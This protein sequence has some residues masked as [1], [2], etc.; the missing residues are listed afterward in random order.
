M[1]SGWAAKT[2]IV[3]TSASSS[4][5]LQVIGVSGE[6]QD[7]LHVCVVKHGPDLS[8][9]ISDEAVDKPTARA[10]MIGT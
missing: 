1:S 2:R 5:G 4:T 7:L 10:A 8:G 9:Q 3:C 6:G